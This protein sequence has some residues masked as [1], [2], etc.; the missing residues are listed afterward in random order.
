MHSLASNPEVAE[1]I[2]GLINGFPPPRSSGAGRE[3]GGGR[4]FLEGLFFCLVFLKKKNSCGL[5][6][7]LGRC[8]GFCLSEKYQNEKASLTDGLSLSL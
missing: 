3:R 1:I 8:S 5:A 4:L 6:G 7:I 2:P